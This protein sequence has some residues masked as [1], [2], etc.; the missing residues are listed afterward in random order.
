MGLSVFPH[1]FG[2]R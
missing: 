2:L 1:D